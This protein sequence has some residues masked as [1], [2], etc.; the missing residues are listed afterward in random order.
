MIRVFE[1][2][3]A[4]IYGW[5]L[6]KRQ[7]W[8]VG[9]VVGRQVAVRS[10][11]R[12]ANDIRITS[13]PVVH[14]KTSTLTTGELL[15]WPPSAVCALASDARTSTLGNVRMPAVTLLP[16]PSISPL[17][18]QEVKFASRKPAFHPIAGCCG[19]LKTD[20]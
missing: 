20:H 17:P 9:R 5:Q 6:H 7:I 13:Y 1:V 16:A 10:K 3:P 19:A 12:L 8:A 4:Q 18:Q 14:Q 15:N 11:A 2:V